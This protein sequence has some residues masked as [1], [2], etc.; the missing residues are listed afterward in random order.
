MATIEEVLRTMDDGSGPEAAATARAWLAAAATPTAART[1]IVRNPADGEALATVALANA[2]EVEAAVMAAGAALPAWAALPA[3]MRARH[4]RALAALVRSRGSLLAEVQTLETG[5]PI[6]ASRSIDLPIVIRS[7]EHYAGA[8]RL[9][10]GDPGRRGPYRS[11]LP[12]EK[13]LAGL[14]QG[15]AAALASGRTAVLMASATAPLTALAFADLCR[16]A[17]LPPG[18]V[19]VVCAASEERAAEPGTLFIVLADADLDAAVEGV[20]EAV[21]SEG[22]AGSCLLVQE[23]VAERLGR[24]LGRRLDTIR[25]GDPLDPSTDLGAVS[26][27]ER[28]AGLRDLLDRA[29]REG[30]TLVRAAAPLPQMGW[31]AAPVLA[32]GVEPASALFGR[33][34]PGPVAAVTTFRTAGEALALAENSGRTRAAAIW[35]SGIEAALDLAT[36][37]RADT[38]WINAVDLVDPAASSTLERVRS[39][40]PASVDPST[41]AR[42]AVARGVVAA[43]E[44]STWGKMPAPDRAAALQG[45]ADA[46]LARTGEAAA[47]L[48]A[49]A[50]VSLVDATHEIEAAAECIA[51]MA[52]RADRGGGRVAATRPRHLVLMLDEPFGLV[53][54]V[55]RPDLSLLGL[56]ALLM[57]ALAAGNRVLLVPPRLHGLA[58]ADVAALLG[59]GALPAGVVTR[60]D[61]EPDDLAAA[62]ADHP[63]VAAVWSSNDIRQD[64]DEI[65][66]ASRTKAVWLPYGI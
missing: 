1:A 32:T 31:F 56:V 28:L 52:A 39:A 25:T 6:R 19:T 30:A 44:A 11:F 35:S 54:L 51:D 21:W 22:T 34:T 48:A 12:A 63:E 45:L 38:V 29:E 58:P 43:G 10:A 50:D 16:D 66:N 53:G 49:A 15:V 33:P 46:L 17:G 4:L 61:G 60:L 40:K 64:A 14:A 55:C 7:V 8:A 5:R 36:A 24:K 65:R 41:K 26:T 2:A 47:R 3:G 23:G 13:P 37:L 9:A 57:P 27:P 59:L 42:D 20:A 62:L 18:V